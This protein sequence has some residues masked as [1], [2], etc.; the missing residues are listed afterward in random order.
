MSASIDRKEHR[1]RSARLMKPFGIA[2][3]VSTM[4]KNQPRRMLLQ[5]EPILTSKGRTLLAIH[6]DAFLDYGQ[7]GRLRNWLSD[8]LGHHAEENAPTYQWRDLASSATHSPH[9]RSK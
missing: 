9:N 3:D 6:A 4:P 7:V 8:W 5:A 2:D 1:T